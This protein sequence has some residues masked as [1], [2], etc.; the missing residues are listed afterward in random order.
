MR[1][2]LLTLLLSV[3]L[4]A[5]STTR[6]RDTVYRPDGGLFTGT[7]EVVAQRIQTPSG[8]TVV[9]TPKTY[10]VLNG[11]L[12]IQL[13]PNVGEPNGT[14]YRATYYIDGKTKMATD[15]WVVPVSATPLKVSNI[16]QSYAPSPS[17]LLPL[18]QVTGGVG[19]DLAG[20]VQTPTVVRVQGIPVAPQQ[21]LDG[22]TWVMDP[23]TH[24][25]TPK[26]LSATA[27]ATYGAFID[28]AVIEDGTCA[29]ASYAAPGATIGSVLAPS[30]PAELSAGLTM[31][32]RVIAA[33]VIGVRICNLSGGPVDLPSTYYGARS[34]DLLGYGRASAALDYPLIEDGTCGNLTVPLIG[35]AVGDNVVAGWPAS[36]EFGLTG[37]AYVSLSN[38]VT[39]RLCNWSGATINPASQTFAVAVT[40]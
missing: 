29:D 3:T 5:Q 38:T 19:G 2:L 27:T 33:D 11:L 30:G 13:V 40:K 10:Q 1:S 21:P 8:Q 34:M 16:W 26:P 24:Q 12:D 28:F 7:V 23:T 39:V 9:P 14:G 37:F 35:A 31:L 20:N 4:M 25:M 36:L 17:A 18:S 15:L 6:I 22:Q 32:T